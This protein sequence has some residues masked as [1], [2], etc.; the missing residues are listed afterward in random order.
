MK[1]GLKLGSDTYRFNVS[2]P[3]ILDLYE[4]SV[5]AYSLRYLSS[6][7]TGDVNTCRE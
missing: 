4:G 2:D 7:N 1:L 3:G 6:T 5:F